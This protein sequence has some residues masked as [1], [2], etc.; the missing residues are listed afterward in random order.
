MADLGQLAIITALLIAA[1]TV[2]AGLLGAYWRSPE[3][4]QSARNGALAVCGL[5]TVA[6]VT[7]MAGFLMHDFSLR[8]V[9]EHSSRDMPPQFVAA[10][11]YSGQQGSLL[12]WAWTLSI[13]SAIVVL[14]NRRAQSP[15]HALRHRRADGALRPSLAW[16]SP[17]WRAR[18]SVAR[19]R[20]PTA[21]G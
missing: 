16:Y 15:A 4:I 2:V 21:W 9:A 10:A 13:F 12:Y 3:L 6:S 17:S 8:Y 1:Y 20:R 7:L 5:L 11:F 14:Q 19:S 18:S